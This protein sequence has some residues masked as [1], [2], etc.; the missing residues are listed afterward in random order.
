M[1]EYASHLIQPM[2][3]EDRSKRVRE[4]DEQEARA[5]R[6]RVSEAMKRM[7]LEPELYTDTIEAFLNQ[8]ETW[9]MRKGVYTVYDKKTGMA[10]QWRVRFAALTGQP[11]CQWYRASS[12]EGEGQSIE[13]AEKDW[14]VQTMC[15]DYEENCE[16]WEGCSRGR[17]QVEP[18]AVTVAE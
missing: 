1:I 16:I 3:G 4:Q 7:L 14:Y 17:P 15:M 2:L 8:F 6:N 10:E 5:V 12:Y 18:M 9:S 13:E 11:F